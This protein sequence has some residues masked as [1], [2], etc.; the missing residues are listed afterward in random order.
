ML[1][2][3]HDEESMYCEYYDVNGSMIHQEKLQDDMEHHFD[4]LNWQNENV[5]NGYERQHCL[6]THEK[7]FYALLDHN[8]SPTCVIF[9][10]ASI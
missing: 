3:H 6:V 5:N 4:L 1:K 7:D 9:K 2:Q 10:K 8:K